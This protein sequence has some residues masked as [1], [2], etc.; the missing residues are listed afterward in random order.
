MPKDDVVVV[1][2]A[3]G[4]IGGRVW[5]GAC[6]INSRTSFSWAARANGR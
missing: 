1:T 2:G 3:A 5:S 6:A 4:F